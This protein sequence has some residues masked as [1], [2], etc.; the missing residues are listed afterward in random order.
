MLQNIHFVKRVIVILGT[1]LYAEVEISFS[2]A[3][4]GIQEL[5]DELN[6]GHIQYAYCRV[7]DPNTDLPKYVLVNWVSCSLKIISTY[8]LAVS[9]LLLDSTIDATN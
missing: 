9:P 1:L 4:N 6:S 2:L 7:V 5:A 3:D 8:M